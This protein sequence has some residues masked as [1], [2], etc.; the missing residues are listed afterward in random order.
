MTKKKRCQNFEA[1]PLTT[2]LPPLT[3]PLHFWRNS[4]SGHAHIDY[5]KKRDYSTSAFIVHLSRD[6]R[7]P[8]MWYM[9]LA[10][11]Q[12]SLRIRTVWSEPLPVPWIF[13]DCYATDRSAFGVSKL[14][15]GCTGSS[16]SMLVKIPHCW[17]SHVMAYF[18]SML[19]WSGSQLRITSPGCKHSF[20]LFMSFTPSPNKKPAKSRTQIYSHNLNFNF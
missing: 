7:F 13:Y 17:K 1:G 8:T 10:K 16:V 9:R 14:K 2:P 3:H 15:G 6:M 12:T 20:R 5:I 4:G 18:V 11:A 19:L